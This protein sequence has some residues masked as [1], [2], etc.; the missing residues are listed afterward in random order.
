MYWFLYRSIRGS[1]YTLQ[2]V[3]LTIFRKRRAP[4]AALAHIRSGANLRSFWWCYDQAS[5][6]E[7]ARGV[8]AESFDAWIEAGGPADAGGEVIGG[9]EAANCER[10]GW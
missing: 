8:E 6:E 2:L 9:V 4:N 5:K 3:R 10:F 1:C 7:R